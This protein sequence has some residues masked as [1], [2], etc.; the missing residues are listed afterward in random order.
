MNQKTKTIGM[1]CVAYL[2]IIYMIGIVY[3]VSTPDNIFT[4]VFPYDSKS[5]YTEVIPMAPLQSIEP[6]AQGN[7]VET[8]LNVLTI[9]ERDGVLSGDIFAA[10]SPTHV[11]IIKK[12]DISLGNDHIFYTFF[13]GFGVYE[14]ASEFGKG[15]ELEFFAP[16]IFRKAVMHFKP[17]VS[18]E[19][20]RSFKESEQIKT[21]Q[22][23]T[24]WGD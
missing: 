8:A 18:I 13:N 9:M 7:C 1:F 11:Q 4:H 14:G 15:A 5:G 10:V 21:T 12:R 16:E 3:T 24:T 19:Q 2:I 17:D 23:K 6:V 20:I 22:I